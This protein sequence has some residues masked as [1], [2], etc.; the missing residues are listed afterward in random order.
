MKNLLLLVVLACFPAL[1]S[2]AGFAPVYAQNSTARANIAHIQL[3]PIA[4][5]AGFTLAQEMQDRGGIRV[6]ENGKYQ[7]Q[8]TL[9]PARRGLGIQVDNVATRFEVQISAKW[10][11]LDPNGNT[12]AQMTANSTSFFDS[13]DNPY[14][15]QVAEQNA[16]DKAV[17]VLADNILDQL[18]FYFA[19]NP[20]SK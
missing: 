12:L 9:T 15:S 10:V 3:T 5:R 20:A 7:L 4:G 2:C 8:I 6:G 19:A 11:L 16:E 14:A 1:T 17:A 18:R 13:P